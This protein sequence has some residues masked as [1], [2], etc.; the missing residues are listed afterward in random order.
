MAARPESG[1]RLRRVPPLPNELIPQVL[2]PLGL[3]ARPA[4]AVSQAW[5]N[6]VSELQ[7]HIPL[8]GGPPYHDEN[9]PEYHP[10]WA[11]PAPALKRM[12]PSAVTALIPSRMQVTAVTCSNAHMCLVT[13]CGKLFVIGSNTTT[14]GG[15]G[16]LGLGSDDLHLP[17]VSSA[18]HARLPTDAKVSQ[19]SCADGNTAV[20]TVDGDIFVCGDYRSTQTDDDQVSFVRI[21]L[22]DGEA[23]AHVSC[24]QEFAM[25]VTRSGK[26]FG[27]GDSRDGKIGFESNDVLYCR[28][29]A[30]PLPEGVGV[31][32]QA[33]CGAHFSCVVTSLGALLG[34]GSSY[35]G[36][37]GTG[38]FE[39]QHPQA[40]VALPLPAGT[41][42]A[43]VSC[44]AFH[45]VVLTTDGVLFSAGRNHL[46]Q[47]GLGVGAQERVSTFRP[48]A[49][50]ESLS[51]A[52]VACGDSHT[53]AVTSGGALLGWGCNDSY[54]LGLPHESKILSPQL[55]PLPHGANAVSA[56]S[57]HATVNRSCVLVRLA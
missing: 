22:P 11:A 47:L 44:G 2:Q 35:F 33:S 5:R 54:K 17:Y 1:D 18:R 41:K 27:W 49:L 39:S 34:C 53:F 10:E 48:V 52:S 36:Q 12:T 45:T 4:A 15:A 26:L 3:Y 8:V 29:T 6:A 9:H 42:A 7:H 25:A 21:R 51:V 38:T 28:V 32:V 30:V 24:G 13:S 43:Q 46:G 56:G 20:V 14:E 57:C 23:A 37:L 50:H 40:L 19:V 16:L 55:I 31:A